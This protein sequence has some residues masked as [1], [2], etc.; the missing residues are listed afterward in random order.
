[1]FQNAQP[2]HH[3]WLRIFCYSRVY[4][5]VTMGSHLCKGEKIMI[6]L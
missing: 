3:S 2:A 6:D 1:M 5:I 4:K